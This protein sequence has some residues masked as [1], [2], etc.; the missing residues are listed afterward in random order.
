MSIKRWAILAAVVTIAAL[1]L[2]ACQPTEVEKIVKETVVVKETVPVEVEKTVVVTAPA[3]PSI[4]EMLETVGVKA[5]DDY[6]VEFTLEH[7]AGFFPAIAGMWVARPVPQWVIEEK[8]DRWTDPGFIVTN[9]PY[10]M[11][12]WVHDDH[13]VFEKNPFYYD[14]DKVQIQKIYGVMIVESST[15]MAM[16]EANELDDSPNPPLEDMDRIKSDPVLSKEYVVYPSDCTYYYGFVTA[17]PPVDNPL[18]RKA[19][20]AAI[21]R[22]TLVDTVLKGGQ[23]P[24]NA[25]A[26]PL[27]FGNV[28]GDPDVCPWCLDYEMGKEKAKEWLA[29]AGYPNGEGWPNDVVLMYNTSEGHKKIAEFIQANWRDVLGINVN[30]EN[31]EWKV[32]LQ[33][34]RNDTP[35]EDAPHI[36][37]LGWCADYPDQNNWVHEVFNPTAGSNNTRLSADDPYVG[38]KIKEFDELTRAAGAESDPA[39]RKEMYKQAEKLLVEEIAA[40]APIYYYTDPDLHKPWLTRGQRG[41]GGYHFSNWTIDWEAKKAATGA[42]GDVVTLNWNLGTEPPTADPGLATDTT[43][44]DVDEQLFLGLT[45]FKDETME[46]IPELA[47]SWEVSEDGLTWTFHMRDDVIWVRYNTATKQVEQVLDDEG[48][49]RKVTAHDVEYA[50]KRTLDPRTASDYAYVLYIIKN[51]EAVNTMSY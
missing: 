21:D 30:V 39:K 24:A 40:M 32:Y 23:Q 35:L 29:E 41:I 14:A 20:S 13:I 22:Q 4:D 34:I 46:V 50:V 36:Y 1:V 33:T 3:G 15:E 7:P 9:G 27:I 5:V 6:T 12:E 38:D 25:F 18:V 44:V 45:D 51:G 28:A 2:P 8:G 49:P 10:V 48:N 37:R 47:T 43:S 19:L 16:Y 17:K 42:T 31:Q 11:T 26:N